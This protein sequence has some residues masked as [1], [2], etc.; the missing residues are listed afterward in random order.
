[1][2]SRPRPSPN[3]ESVEDPATQ[4]AL[5][6]VRSATIRNVGTALSSHGDLQL[7]GQ[8]RV[9]P[10]DEMRLPIVRR[11]YPFSIPGSQGSADMNRRVQ[12]APYRTRTIHTGI[13]PSALATT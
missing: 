3:R 2:P 13:G 6:L 5:N 9:V 7:T 8:F 1:M 12:G 11:R 4:I 10:C